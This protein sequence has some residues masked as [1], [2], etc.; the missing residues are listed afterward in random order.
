[1]HTVDHPPSPASSSG[2]QSSSDVTS[3]SSAPSPT[4]TAH[5]K[6][7]RKRSE[8]L[9]TV[10]A[11]LLKRLEDI[12]SETQENKNMFTTFT[13]YLNSFLLQLPEHDAKRLVKEIH[14]L[15][16]CYG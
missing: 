5:E 14:Q 7:K 1:M 6:K 9:T 16:L 11:A 3:P 10:D 4:G 13:T 15:M 12:R 8:E 2:T